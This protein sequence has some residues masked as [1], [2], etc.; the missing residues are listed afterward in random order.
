MPA[1][2]E[3]KYRAFISYSHTDA[4][5]A[6]WLHSSVEGF[7]VDKDLVGAATAMG[8]APKSLRPIFR[9]RDEFTAGHTLT[10]QTRAAIDSSAALIVLCSPAGAK[11]Y[12]VN[13]EIRLFKS[14]H[15]ERPVIPVIVDGKP[16]DRKTE[17]FPPALRFKV[18]TN[19]LISTELDE[20][21]AADVREEADG[22]DLALAKV[23]AR[24]LG[25][26]TDDVFRRAERARRRSVRIRNGTITVLAI[27]LVAVMSSAA[28]AWYQS[29]VAQREQ[30]LK[31]ISATYELLY[32]DP[33]AAFLKAY[34]ASIL[35]PGLEA[36]AA[37]KAAYK[38]AVLHHYNRREITQITGSGPS[39]LAGR[40]K[41]GD[42]FTKA[43]PDGRYRLIVTERGQDGPNPPG[44]VYLLNNESLRTTKLEPCFDH[45]PRVEDVSFDQGSQNVLVSRYFKLNIYSL[46]GKCI[47]KFD[48]G[49]YTK[50][51]VHL[52]EGHIADRF[53]IAAET[54]GG[55]WLVDPKKSCLSG[56]IQ[57]Q[58]EFH[59]DAAMSA[60]LSPDRRSATV[61]F[62][63]GRA[64]LVSV[65]PNTQPHLRDFIKA[66]ALFAGFYPGRNDQLVT[67]GDDGS[68]RHW[69]IS[70][71]EIKEIDSQRLPD[72]AID[73]ITFSDD[74]EQ[75]LA[76]GDNRVL[77]VIDH[78]NGRVL[79][80]MGKAQDIDWAEWAEARAMPWQP[81]SVV[82]ERVQAS[83]SIA[84]PDAALKVIGALQAAGRTWVVTEKPDEYVSSYTTYLVDGAR[85]V[86]YPGL[87]MKVEAIEQHG[88]LFWLKSRGIFGGEISGPVV[89]IDDKEV[90]FYP[91]KSVFVNAIIA[92][93]GKSYLATNQGLYVADE[94]H[95]TRVTKDTIMVQGLYPLGDQ[96]WVATKQGAYVLDKE[97]LIRVT[98]PFLDVQTIKQVAER[99]W[100]LTNS[101]EAFV[102]AGPA[103][104]VEN[105][106]ARP[107]PNR[108][109]RVA[110]VI[111]AG[112]KTW[113]LGMPGLHV[114]N[115]E[116]AIEVG[117]IPQ[118]VIDLQEEHGR[119]FAKTQTRN[120]PYTNP[121]PTYEINLNTLK[122]L[123][124]TT[125]P[126]G[127]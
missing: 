24:L 49:C 66:H 45:K 52:I 105:Y 85:A 121:G 37:L 28:F 69:Q 123:E 89:R 10:G 2:I 61:V 75:M 107:F 77:Y 3:I 124:V 88:N 74:G 86:T 35:L 51:P 65:E 11:S 38:V 112:G 53:V 118:D 90:L 22:R 96:L 43:S 44:D 4:R 26:G 62:A 98:E 108:N 31:L 83:V 48:L 114:L 126:V 91:K 84:Y 15:P 70:G 16:G 78:R 104:L 17:C 82:P 25:L 119:V 33:S 34:N 30:G 23:V 21:V 46:S 97:R 79:T 6:K 63:S 113:L 32:R 87:E 8:P 93:Q 125:S 47:G 67:T 29:I 39:Y 18:G 20:V 14:Q 92:Y 94:K 42:V 122:A 99:V 102:P 109:A 116:R 50:S 12:Y 64:G 81:V 76:V 9:D 117:S 68:I 95:L 36:Q 71:N 13:E 127:R 80:E 111:E 41:Q 72:V 7:R 100:L 40:W 59:G 110:N 106:F 54:K 60:T 73:W 19:G 56:V 101:G 58:R 120:F 27:L 55:L 115:G 1:P 57:F 5:W 103:Y